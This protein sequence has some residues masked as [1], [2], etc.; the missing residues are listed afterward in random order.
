[1]TA[2]DCLADQ[3]RWTAWRNELGPTGKPTKIPH[4]PW[5]ERA[6]IDDPASWVTLREAEAC[7][8]Q[9]IDGLGGGVMVALGDLGDD[10]Y[11]SGLDLDG[12]INEEGTL[13]DWAAAIL[14]A[15]PT[16]AE[17]S[18]SG[19]GL[20]V[21]F[22]VESTEV[23]PLLDAIGAAHRQWG[24][25]RGVP[26]STIAITVLRSRSIWRPGSSR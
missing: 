21:F 15:A 23:R 26:A 5:R 13:A 3:A 19:R 1:M 10:Q 17:I 18:P 6:K 16:Y 11:L 4:T 14:V 7:A 20:K 2:L 22:F 9:I 24:V 12:C 25:R 8:R